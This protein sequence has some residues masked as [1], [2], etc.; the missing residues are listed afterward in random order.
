LAPLVA[1][2]RLLRMGS[3]EA[4]MSTLLQDLR[5]ALRQLARAPGFAAVVVLTLAIGIGANTAIFG[6]IDAVLLKPLPFADAHTIVRLYQHNRAQS[7]ERGAAAP[8][9]FYDWRERARS[10]EILAAADPSSVDFIGEE[11]PD[12]LQA[13]RV[14]EEFFDVFGV[15]PLIGRT[16]RYDDYTAGVAPVAVLGYS[17]WQSKF[18][19]DPGIVG[20][21]LALSDQPT[22]V[23]GVMPPHF[24]FPPRNDAWIPLPPQAPFRQLRGAGFW[25]VAGKLA[26]GVGAEAAQAELD[27]I[28]VQLAAEYPASNTG[29]G[30]SALPIRESLVGELRS[31]LLLFFAA[32]GAVLLIACVNVANLQLARAADRRREFAIRSVCGAGRG[33]VIRQLVTESVV[34]AALGGGL[35][36][37][38]AAWMLYALESLRPDSLA[39][40]AAL[41]VDGRALLFGLLLALGT[42][43]L[44]G[45]TPATRAAKTDVR[46]RLHNTPRMAT[47]AGRR[48]K[49]AL[50]VAELALAMVL[51]IGAGL[52]VRSLIE[53]LD[54]DRGYR[55]E[56]V[57]AVTVQAWR[58]Y[59]DLDQRSLFVDQTLERIAALPGVS[60]AGVASA[61]P[62]AAEI[63]AN[64][65]TF[66]IEGRSPQ[67]DTALP[68]AR[69]VVVTSGYFE[70]LG[71]P[72]LGGRSV[73]TTDKADT[74]R[75][76]LINETMARR[77]WGNENPVGARLAVD[78]RGEPQPAE[79]VGVV[80]DTRQALEDEPPASIFVPY[81]QDRTGALHFIVRAAGDSGALVRAVQQTIRAINPAMPFAGAT[82]LDGLVDDALRERRYTLTLVLAFSLTALALAAIGTYGVLSYEAGRRAHEIG[83]RVALG[84]RRA[85]IM[86]LVVG[87]G[88]RLAL[89]GIVVGTVLAL[90]TTRLLSRF[91]FGVTPFDPLTFAGIAVLLLAVAALASYLPARRAARVGPVVALRAE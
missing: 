89:V 46:E 3:R 31:T 87:Q 48:F 66:A 51:L 24:E 37:L 10:F 17:A 71:V 26:P 59:P 54:V 55:T 53:L 68:T 81:D 83:V 50:V 33:R 36:L 18:G 84:A 90:A 82:T 88:V 63:G 65:A 73:Q 61:L 78:F 22:V 49:Q 16:L 40:V 35:G 57:A 20:R 85:W 91:L 21:T 43:L 79:V 60:A 25:T 1:L 72:L 19:G 6:A 34:L 86:H 56:N 64:R 9:N 4:S 67:Q 11:G 69:A 47:P 7:V 29:V 76:V 30:V 15:P 62:L 8:A 44:F 42:V 77:Y 75:V 27:A 74:P 58:Y 41:S 2:A 12:R 80:G 45:L 23:V 52:L 38:V 70:A 14:T 32:V 5:Y 28:S 13:Q 39:H